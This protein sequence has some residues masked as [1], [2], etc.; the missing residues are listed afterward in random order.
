VNIYSNN[1]HDHSMLN[2]VMYNPN[3]NSIDKIMNQCSKIEELYERLLQSE[4][5]KVKLLLKANQTV[6]KLKNEIKELNLGD[7]SK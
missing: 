7:V 1:F 6:P 5:E 4:Q 3:F 2:G